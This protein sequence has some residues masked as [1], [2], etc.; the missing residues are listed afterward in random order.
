[1]L[2]WAARQGAAQ[3]TQQVVDDATDE[4][5][6]LERMANTAKSVNRTLHAIMTSLTV[7]GTTAF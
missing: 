5:G 2:E 1:M 7:S 6:E 4:L 3:I